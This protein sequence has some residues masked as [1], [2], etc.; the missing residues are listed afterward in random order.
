MQKVLNEKT[1]LKFT[2]HLGLGSRNDLLSRNNLMGTIRHQFS[3]RLA[4]EVCFII[5]PDLLLNE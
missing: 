2:S 3:P 5:R 1:N 4:L